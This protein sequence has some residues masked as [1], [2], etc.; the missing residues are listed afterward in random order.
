MMK[1]SQFITCLLGLLPASRVKNLLLRLLGHKVHPSAKISSNFLLG[2][3][4]LNIGTGVTIRGFNVFRDT[5]VMLD[6]Q[7]IIGSFN[8]F[9]S[10]KSLT[11]YPNYKGILQLGQSCAI[12]SR[13]YFDCSGGI[14]FGEF[15][16]LAGVRST[17][18]THYVDTNINNQ[19]CKAISIGERT[20]LSSNIQVAPG[21]RVGSKSLIAMGT[22]L[23]D[24]EYPSNSLIA[25][26]PGKFKSHREGAWFERTIGPSGD[27]NL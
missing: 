25:G 14:H 18:I 24:A 7:A 17:F 3:V 11:S 9:S 15:S 16:D 23:I 5:S 4:H 22:V 6:Q 12:N 10:A 27:M 1:A 26:V 8:W 20:M 13:N 2:T 21:A 19:R